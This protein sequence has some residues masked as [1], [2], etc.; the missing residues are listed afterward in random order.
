MELD[1]SL[2]STRTITN[3]ICN[4]I[5]YKLTNNN[6]IYKLANNKLNIILSLPFTINTIILEYNNIY[7]IIYDGINVSSRVLIP[8]Y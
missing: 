4:N 8:N 2:L 1:I 7:G 6:I 5:I 3:V